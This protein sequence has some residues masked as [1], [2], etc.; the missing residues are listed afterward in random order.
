MK[1]ND[2]PK[3][4]E[5]N[6]EFYKNSILLFFINL[7]HTSIMS[8]K[9]KHLSKSALRNCNDASGFFYLQPNILKTNYKNFSISCQNHS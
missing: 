6:Y 8:I 5:R 9:N 7:I 4:F 3:L 1:T 2:I